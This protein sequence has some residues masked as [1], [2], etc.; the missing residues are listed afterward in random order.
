MAR[1]KRSF[2]RI[3]LDIPGSIALY[4]TEAY[5][6]GSITNI[7]LSGCFFP[8]DEKLPIGEQCAITITVGEGLETEE[9]AISGIIVRNDSQGVGIN[10]TDESPGCKEQLLKIISR[11]SAEVEGSDEQQYTLLK[12]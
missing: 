1:E 3:T 5:H 12:H 8:I 11:E 6:S 9:I 4:Q 7:S 2:T 10:F